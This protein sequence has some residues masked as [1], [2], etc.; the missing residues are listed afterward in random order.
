MRAILIA[1]AVSALL[2]ASGCRRHYRTDP[3]YDADRIERYERNLVRIAARDS[4]CPPTYVAPVR[5]ADTVWGVNTCSGP[6]EYFLSCRSRGR[7][8]ANCR[9]DPIEPMVEAAARA[10]QCP[11][12][13]LVVQNGPVATTRSAQGCNGSVQLSLRCSDVGC[14]W[15]PD[16]PPAGTT[17]IVV[18]AQ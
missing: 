12:H 15:L 18:P 3:L 1:A 17:V 4:G 16:G 11:P 6:R 8:W 9:W 14:G 13:A 10:L 2:P 5:I 7:R